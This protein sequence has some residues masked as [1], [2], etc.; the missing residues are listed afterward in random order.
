M[1]A[2]ILA[3]G[4][5]TRMLPITKT[6]PKE[7]LPVGNKPIIQYAVEGLSEAGI[8]D[9]II[10]TSQGKRALEDYFDKNYELE[11]LL[12]KKGKTELLEL[13]NKPKELANYTFVKQT[14]QLGTGHAVSQIE[15]WITD[16]YFIVAFGDTIYPPN[17]FKEMKKAFQEKNTSLIVVHEVPK[18]DVSKYG[19]V[20]LDGDKLI[21]FVE[22]PTIEEAPSNLMWNGVALLHKDIFAILKDV[23]P[24]E[25]TWE[26]Y[27]PTAILDLS[28]KMDVNA[29]KVNPYWDTGMVET[30]LEANVCIS[31]HGRLFDDN[32]KSLK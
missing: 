22:K 18:E 30:W 25:K 29:V 28:K 5:G 32:G 15:S 14:E 7:L 4:F 10:I 12:K 17:M 13:I 11:D 3:A 24:D 1:K 27:L 6:I 20:S 31:K 23:E 21:D 19:I 9:L 2:V 8:K 16:E 26:I